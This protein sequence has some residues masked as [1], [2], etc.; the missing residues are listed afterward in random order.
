MIFQTI[1]KDD[2]S[3]DSIVSDTNI[4]ADRMVKGILCAL[5]KR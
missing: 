3:W 4:L 1:L 5:D 2:V